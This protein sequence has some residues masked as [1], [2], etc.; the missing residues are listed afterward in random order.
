[1]GYIN[2]KDV[3]P[4]HLLMELQ[5][6]VEGQIIYIPKNSRASWG[7]LNGTREVFTKRNRT[8]YKLYKNGESIEDLMDTFHLSE[9]SIRKIIA[10]V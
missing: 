3:L 8:I 5:K 9:E 6:Y 1:M 2:A 10:N 7:E 4:D